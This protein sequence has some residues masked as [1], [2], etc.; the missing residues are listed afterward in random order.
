MFA[1][2]VKNVQNRV[3]QKTYI[4]IL[5][6]GVNIEGEAVSGIFVV[7]LTQKM[8]VCTFFFAHV[9]GN[10]NFEKRTFFKGQVPVRFLYVF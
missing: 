6:S 8:Y 4:L 3:N 9:S 10:P 7:Q 2:L 1:K 5:I